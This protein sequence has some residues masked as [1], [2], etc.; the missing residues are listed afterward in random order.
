[1][2][3]VPGESNVADHLTKAKASWEFRELLEAV[4]GRM[5]GRMCSRAETWGGKKRDV[6]RREGGD[7]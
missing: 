6:E 4:G 5:V 7:V 2:A 1:M 3:K